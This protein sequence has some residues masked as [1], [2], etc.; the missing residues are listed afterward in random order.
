MN[1]LKKYNITIRRFI[2]SDDRCDPITIDLDENTK[3]CTITNNFG[4]TYSHCWRGFNTEDNDFIKFF[5]DADRDWSY[6]CDKLG[7]GP[8]QFNLKKS[9]REALRCFFSHINRDTTKEDRVDVIHAIQDIDTFDP[10]YFSMKAHA[11]IDDYSD[12][13]ECDFEVMEW[14]GTENNMRNALKALALIIRNE[15]NN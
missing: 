7:I 3:T 11:I 4:T 13:W 9:K 12:A 14:A 10:Q 2:F 6:F 5:S 15:Y 8:T 1:L